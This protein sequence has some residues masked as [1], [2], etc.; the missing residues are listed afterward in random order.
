MKKRK[1]NF[2]L[3][4]TIVNFVNRTRLRDASVASRTLF[5]GVSVKVFVEETLI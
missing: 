3:R 2:R 5:L 1:N 4:H